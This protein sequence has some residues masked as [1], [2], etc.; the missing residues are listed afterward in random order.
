MNQIY[1]N[2]KTIL[3]QTFELAVDELADYLSFLVETKDWYS[4]FI[5]FSRITPKA[6]DFFMNDPY[7]KN[8]L[9][10]FHLNF[11]KNYY[12]S[13]YAFRKHAEAC[14]EEL[15]KVLELEDL[16]ATDSNYYNIDVADYE[17]LLGTYR[18]SIIKVVISTESEKLFYQWDNTSKV[19]LYPISKGSFIHGFDYGFNSIQRDSS[20]Q[21]ISHD[22]HFGELQGVLKKV[23]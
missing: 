7:Y 11:I 6:V 13:L 21:V 17:H 12:I 19:R 16:T 20:G 4:E 23:E 9:S 1:V 3:D 15:T 18:D 14:Y 10:S 2:D 5:Y 22:W 8:H